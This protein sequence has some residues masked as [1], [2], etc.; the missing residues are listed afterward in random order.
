MSDPKTPEDTTK[1]PGKETQ[2]SV[3]TKDPV[4]DNGKQE[5][6][7]NLLISIGV[8]I[9][10]ILAASCA[11]VFLTQP[12]ATKGDT[13]SVYYTGM[14]ENGTVFDSNMNGTPLEFTLGNASVISGF[15]D[16]VSGM[17]KNQEKTITIPYD[18]AYGAY[19]PGLVQI[20][21]R[22]GP[23]ANTSFVQ[24]QSY[25]IHDRTTNTNSK[26]MIL[27]VTPETV[28][29]DANNRLAGQNLTFTIKLANVT[30]NQ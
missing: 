6:Q 11:F 15:E 30:R 28:T 23:I 12:V 7:R 27:N 17:S 10:I 24:G 29:I 1:S 9:V 8:A 20:V 18:K 21:N 13:I 4:H 2:K 26:I 14:L 22:T 16:A 5:Q 19:N 25:V 3:E